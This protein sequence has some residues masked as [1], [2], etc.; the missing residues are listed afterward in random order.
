[1]LFNDKLHYDQKTKWMPKGESLTKN[2]IKIE[3]NQRIYICNTA[4]ACGLRTMKKKNKVRRTLW[5]VRIFP[6]C[7]RITQWKIKPTLFYFSFFVSSKVF[8]LSLWE[9]FFR[10]K[11][12]WR[13]ISNF[14]YI[15]LHKHC[16]G[17]THLLQ[18]HM[19]HILFFSSSKLN[20]AHFN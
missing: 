7:L 1:M 3:A 9:F 6:H 11:I 17:F 19:K 12:R 8:L 13:H 16:V 14:G 18:F 5:R 2:W 20:F 15:H 10:M 4:E